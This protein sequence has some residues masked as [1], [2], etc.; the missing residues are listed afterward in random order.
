[1]SVSLCISVTLFLSV[2]L[3]VFLHPSLRPLSCTA[4]I[5]S[6]AGPH[7]RRC[8]HG[9]WSWC[10]CCSRHRLCRSLRPRCGVHWTVTLLLI[11]IITITSIV[12]ICCWGRVHAQ[13]LRQT[14][15]RLATPCFWAATEDADGGGGRM[16]ML[17]LQLLGGSL[18]IVLLGIVLNQFA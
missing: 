18:G 4:R 16:T 1:M 6:T 8:H 11:F 14:D 2:C 5:D 17:L 9:C 3:S 12:I 13:Y 7:S 10:L 15:R